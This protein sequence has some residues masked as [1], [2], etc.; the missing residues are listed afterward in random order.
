MKFKHYLI[1]AAS[2]MAILGSGVSYADATASWH[3]T[4]E[5]HR[6]A[7]N[8]D[9]KFIAPI[10]LD[11]TLKR[12][13]KTLTG[14]LALTDAQRKSIQGLADSAN[15]QIEEERVK[16]GDAQ[17]GLDNLHQQKITSPEQFKT[18]HNLLNQ[19]ALAMSNIMFAKQQFLMSINNIVLVEKQ[20]EAVET[21][22]K[23]KAEHYREDPNKWSNP[24]RQDM[25]GGA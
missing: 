1:T 23:E 19:R 14:E 16:L 10:D 17:Q 6:K 9:A 12:L 8:K 22:L 4:T 3:A 24:R 25:M 7:Q 15:K 13:D 11:E 20:R 18:L 2:C 21:K 5:H